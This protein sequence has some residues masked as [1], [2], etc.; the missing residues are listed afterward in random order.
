M[1]SKRSVHPDVRFLNITDDGILNLSD[2]QVCIWY[3]ELLTLKEGP[4]KC[5]PSSLSSTG[6]SEMEKSAR[7]HVAKRL[8]NLLVFLWRVD[9]GGRF[10]NSIFDVDRLPASIVVT[11]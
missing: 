6:D 1:H 7:T 2:R 5:D 11:D 8:R 4:V 10:R 3:K 9:P